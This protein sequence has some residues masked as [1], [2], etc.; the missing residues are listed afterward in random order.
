[1]TAIIVKDEPEEDAPT[2]PQVVLCPETHKPITLIA[3]N[4]T[5]DGRTVYGFTWKSIMRLASKWWDKTGRKE[6]TRLQGEWRDPDVGINSGLT[7]AKPWEELN[8]RERVSVAHVY[9]EH[10]LRTRDDVREA[11]LEYMVLNHPDL[12]DQQELAK[13]IAA[14]PEDAAAELVQA[15]VT[16]QGK[17]Q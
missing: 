16:Q 5:D 10:H 9:E 7:R 6:M 14:L 8:A 4:M 2:F 1:M 11:L 3:P 12:L 17:P 13:Y 15:Y